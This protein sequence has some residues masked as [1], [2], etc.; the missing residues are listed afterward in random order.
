MAR[1]ANG[2]GTYIHI[3]PIKCHNC[4]EFS[5]C[6]IKGDTEKRC[7]KRDVGE[8]WVYQYYVRDINGKT[9]RK[10]LQ[11]KTRRQ[12]EKRVELLR[13]G[14]S[15]TDTDAVTVGQWCD[16][17][18]EKILPNTVKKSTL[19]FYKNL[20]KYSSS[21]RKKRLSRLSVL[22]LQGLYSDLL[23]H[24]GKDGKS[25]SPTTVR[26]FRATL[27]TCF[28]QA[29]EHGYLTVNVAKKSKPPM[30]TE[31]E[32]SYLTQEQIQKLLDVVDSAAFVSPYDATIDD[33]ARQYNIRQ[34]SMVIRLALAT[35]MRRG[36]IFGLTWDRVDF[37]K[38]TVRI[39]RNLQGG[40]LETPKTSY[41]VRT[42]S[43]DADTVERL[44]AWQ[45]YQ[46]QFA[47]EMGD[48]YC[49]PAGL[50]FSNSWGNPV[51]MSS[52]RSRV[53]VPVVAA[54]GLPDTVTMHSLRHTHA[55]Q[56]LAAGVDAKTVSARLGHSSVAF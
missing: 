55:T 37:D 2:D 53:F 48:L 30:K 29:V 43:V 56:L 28:D 6:P 1:R 26:S 35:G 7:R 3:L 17:W 12:L 49:N 16:M 10:A 47:D 40:R 15:S 18:V 23:A 33:P 31:K 39:D 38:R 54:A 52:F 21:I 51:N 13:M 24:G 41:S 50:L 19:A 22:D 11:A 27:I 44:R 45:E 8:H 46:K 36:E 5:G 4:K 32:V 25:L 14:T 9:M 20:I 42:I 34:V